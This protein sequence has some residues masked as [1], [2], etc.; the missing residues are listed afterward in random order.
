MTG[1][2]GATEDLQIREVAR[3]LRDL[4]RKWQ[5]TSHPS[6][7]GAVSLEQYL[8]LHFLGHSGPL[9]VSQVA[10][11]LGTTVS[12]ATILT[13]RMERTGLVRRTRCPED[14]RVVEVTLLPLGEQNLVTWEKER[15]DVLVRLLSPL[16]TDA[17]NQL[18]K[19]LQQLI[20]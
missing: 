8:V 14:S 7:K 5:R 1:S 13:Q 12:A 3:L 2:G 15:Q 9:P 16:P 19:I 17:I 20:P 6:K 10:G 11:R 18:S 4:W